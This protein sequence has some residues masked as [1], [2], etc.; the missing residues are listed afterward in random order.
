M[1]SDAD[2]IRIPQQYGGWQIED[3]LL[4]P[5]CL[6][7]RIGLWLVKGQQKY[8]L[9]VLQELRTLAPVQYIETIRRTLT[10]PPGTIAS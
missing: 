3:E 4:M 7:S 9:G 6:G 1:L 8:Y 5:E 2:I 10:S